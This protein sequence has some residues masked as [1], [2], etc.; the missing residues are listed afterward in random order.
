MALIKISDVSVDKAD[1]AALNQGYLYKDLFLDILNR[2][3]Y[4]NQL[5]RTVEIRDVQ[6]LYDLE[7]IK[8]SIV[9][10]MMTSPGQKIL[11]PRFGIDLRRY[12]FEPVS[13]FTSFE[14][15]SDI[16]DKL[17]R[18]EPRISLEKIGVKAN[19]DNQEYRISLQ[20]NVPSLDITGL[21]L[22]S[23]LNSNGY[24]IV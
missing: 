5:N 2:V 15:R 23:I 9:N 22:K 11:S 12:L 10:I 1:D 20:I 8:N 18:L 14:I 24:T 16:R 13:N 21:S 19:V 17:P 3:S 7:S 6:G 4:N